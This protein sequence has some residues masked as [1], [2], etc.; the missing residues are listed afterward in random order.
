MLNAGKLFCEIERTMAN[1]DETFWNWPLERISSSV[2]TTPDLMP[3]FQQL[4]KKITWL[5]YLIKK[6]VLILQRLRLIPIP[7][8]PLNWNIQF[9][10]EL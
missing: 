3:F 4:V 6:V 7:K 2:R 5:G 10:V 9:S 1:I 8:I